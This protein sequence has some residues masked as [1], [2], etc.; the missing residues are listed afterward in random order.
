ML[1]MFGMKPLKPGSATSASVRL[2]LT[3]GM[4]D[5]AQSIE[6]LSS[7][8]VSE[9]ANTRGP[10]ADGVAANTATAGPAAITAPATT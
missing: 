2:S 7:V 6:K 9:Q 4:T 10:G 1:A 3:S 5:G 8:S